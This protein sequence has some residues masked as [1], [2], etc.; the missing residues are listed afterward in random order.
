[1]LGLAAE[2]GLGGDRLREPIGITPEALKAQNRS[3]SHNV[4]YSA[5]H[6]VGLRAIEHLLSMCCHRGYSN[7]VANSVA[8]VTTFRQVFFERRDSKHKS[9]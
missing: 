2:K 5:P 8:D 7:F 3:P 4:L 9:D 6:R 1:M